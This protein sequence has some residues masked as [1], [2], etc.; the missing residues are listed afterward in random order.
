MGDNGSTGGVGG[1]GETGVSRIIA[2]ERVTGEG[3]DGGVKAGGL[4]GGG[5][6]GAAWLERGERKISLSS[7]G[8]RKSST[9]LRLFLTHLEGMRLPAAMETALL[10][11]RSRRMGQ[12]SLA[13]TAVAE[14]DYRM[15]RCWRRLGRA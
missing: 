7:S 13:M 12:Q 8:S 2:S 3:G 9:S 15:R 6:S 1:A 4:L 5:V 11:E 14:A 10:H